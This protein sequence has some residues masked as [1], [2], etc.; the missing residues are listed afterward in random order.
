MFL[1][2]DT[3]LGV[4][5]ATIQVGFTLWALTVLMQSTTQFSTDDRRL[6]AGLKE[7]DTGKGPPLQQYVKSSLNAAARQRIARKVDRALGE[8]KIFRCGS[9]QLKSLCAHINE[10]PHYVSQVINQDFNST[11]YELINRHRVEDAKIMLVKTPDSTITEI[12]MAVGFN[13]KSTFNAAFRRHTRTTPTAFRDTHPS[14]L[15]RL[16]QCVPTDSEPER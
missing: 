10:I 4:Y 13:S 11:F 15:Q 16:H 9:L 8:E 7:A 12:A 14:R 5:F 3:G 2:Q 6:L 1:G